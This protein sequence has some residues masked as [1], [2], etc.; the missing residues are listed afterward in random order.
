MKIRTI[1]NISLVITALFFT[2]LA[3]R[4]I[5]RPEKLKTVYK[6][7]CEEIRTHLTTIRAVQQVYR[8]EYKKYADSIDTLVEFVNNGVVHIVQTS[9]NIPEEMTEA[10]ALEEGLIISA[11]LTIPAKDRIVRSDPNVTYESLKNFEYIPYSN[12]KKFEIQIGELSGKT[13]TIPV[14]RIDVTLEDI[15]FNLDRT[16]SKKDAG[17]VTVFFNKLFYNNLTNDNQYKE[18]FLPMWLGSLSDA[19]TSGSWE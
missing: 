1:I 12:G 19:A 18:K 5:L 14:Y 8:N 9:G 2:L 17:I 13:Y 7:R 16:I 15:L 6:Q 3:S 4:S 10:R 11:V